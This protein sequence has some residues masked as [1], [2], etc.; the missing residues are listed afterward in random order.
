M[1]DTHHEGCE[2]ETREENDVSNYF[3]GVIRK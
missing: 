1:P 2:F 3:T